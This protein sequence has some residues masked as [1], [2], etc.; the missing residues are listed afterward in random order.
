MTFEERD[1]SVQE[2]HLLTW[3]DERMSGDQSNWSRPEEEDLRGPPTLEPHIQEFLRGEEILPAS[4]G[5]WDSLPPDNP[6]PSSMQ[7]TEWIK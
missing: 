4:T 5:V 6:E 7:N 1:T 3:G 2:P